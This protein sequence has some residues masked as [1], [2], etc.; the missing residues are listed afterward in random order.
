MKNIE[1]IDT[2]LYSS[3]SF[4]PHESQFNLQRMTPNGYADVGGYE[5]YLCDGGTLVAFTE[6]QNG[7]GHTDYVAAGEDFRFRIQLTLFEDNIDLFD[8]ISLY[9]NTFFTYCDSRVV[10]ENLLDDTIFI[11]EE[12]C[13]L[14]KYGPTVFHSAAESV[15]YALLRVRVLLSVTGSAHILRTDLSSM[16]S[17]QPHSDIVKTTGP[18]LSM[19]FKQVLEWKTYSEP[20]FNN[21]EP[22]AIKASPFI[23]GL[24]I[25]QSCIDEISLSVPSMRIQKIMDEN[26]DIYSLIPDCGVF[27]DSFKSYL[28]SVFRYS[29]VSALKK[30][31]PLA[32]GIPDDVLLAEKSAIEGCVMA[33]CLSSG[34]DIDTVTAKELHYSTLN[35]TLI[36]GKDEFEAIRK[37]AAYE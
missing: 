9:P 25:P 24:N 23:D 15:N 7:I 36:S 14:L 5:L 17:D 34:I 29:T 21:M 4:V 31:T 13:D 35:R 32:G 26:P 3:F 12:R 22:A 20:P 19:A 28:K 6:E 10:N 8:E 30:H 11:P 1:E 33:W 27:P 37:F 16:S 2:S 18:S